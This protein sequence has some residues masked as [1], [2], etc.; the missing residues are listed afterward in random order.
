MDTKHPVEKHPVDIHVGARIR[1]RRQ[2]IGMTQQALAEKVGVK[3]QQI[4][5]YE[6]GINRVSASRLWGIAKALGVSVG[7]FFKDYSDENLVDPA[8]E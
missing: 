4:Q 5:K 8:A 7:F 1:A 2:K 3:F 6:T